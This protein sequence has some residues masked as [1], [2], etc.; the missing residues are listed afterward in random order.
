MSGRTNNRKFC[1][2]ER[3]A[4]KDRNQEL[5]SFQGNILFKITWRKSTVIV[6]YLNGFTIPSNVLCGIS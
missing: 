3:P 5:R 2:E 6:G 1:Y 4:K